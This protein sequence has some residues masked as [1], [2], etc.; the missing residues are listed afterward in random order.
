MH[1]PQ[2]N[3][4]KVVTFSAIVNCIHVPMFCPCRWTLE[5]QLNQMRAV[6]ER[7]E[8]QQHQQHEQHLQVQAAELIQARWRTYCSARKEAHKN[9]DS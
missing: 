1:L 5:D 4:I 9:T 8:H 7:H 3:T 2:T 6:H